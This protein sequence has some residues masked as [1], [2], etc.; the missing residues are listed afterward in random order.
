MKPPTT[1][2]YERM[3]TPLV[4]DASGKKNGAHGSKPKRVHI[5][6]DQ[7]LFVDYN[8]SERRRCSRRYTESVTSF[9]RE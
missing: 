1:N 9:L 8:G 5:R 3:R 7:R 4:T 6:R 2:H